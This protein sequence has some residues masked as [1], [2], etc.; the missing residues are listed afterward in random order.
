MEQWSAFFEEREGSYRGYGNDDDSRWTWNFKGGMRD[1]DERINPSSK[2]S[3]TP[4]NGKGKGEING[5]RLR[6]VA[7]ID[8]FNSSGG[9]GMV[10]QWR[11][12]Q[13]FSGLFLVA[14]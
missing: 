11:C 1:M 14:G 13:F 9:D 6:N 10:A 7:R 2:S 8:A 3:K 5:N 4:S 12:L